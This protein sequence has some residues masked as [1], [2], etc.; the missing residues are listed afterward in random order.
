MLRESQPPRFFVPT[1]NKRLSC[2]LSECKAVACVFTLLYRRDSL[3][4]AKRHRRVYKF[5][6][7]TKLSWWIFSHLR[8][9][10]SAAHFHLMRKMQKISDL[11]KLAD[12]DCCNC[13][14]GLFVQRRRCMRHTLN[15][16]LLHQLCAVDI[17]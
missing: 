7:V 11:Y 9:A 6:Y 2:S 15:Q 13:T 4:S 17:N 14:H 12:I 3:Q 1:I 5:I 8:R 10:E 16:Q